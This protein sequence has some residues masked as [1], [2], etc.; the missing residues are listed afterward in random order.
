MRHVLVL[1]KKSNFRLKYFKNNH[2]IFIKRLIF[3]SNDKKTITVKTHLKSNV[4][5]NLNLI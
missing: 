3:M 2:Y 5:K 1:P 4:E